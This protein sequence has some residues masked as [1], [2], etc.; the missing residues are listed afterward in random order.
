MAK[1]SCVK[2]LDNDP[3]IIIRTSYVRICQGDITAAALLSIFEYWH[4]SKLAARKNHIDMDE[5]PVT[6]TPPPPLWQYHKN[7]DLEDQ[8]MGIGKRERIDRARKLLQEMGIIE[9]GRNPNKK[10]KFDA[11]TFY[12]FHPEILNDYLDSLAAASAENRTEPL[13]KAETITAENSRAI[14]KDSHTSDSM[15]KETADAGAPGGMPRQDPP[16]T[17]KAPRKAPGAEKD[18]DWQ[19]WVDAWFDFFKARHGEIAPMFN[20]AQSAALKGLRQYL[21]KVAT[22]IEGKT[23]DDAGFAAW[24]YIL[25]NWDRLREW[26]QEQFDLTVVLKKIN[27][28]LNSLRNGNK[29]NRGTNSSGA[30]TSQQRVDAIKN[31]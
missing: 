23:V 25:D 27:D 3:F 1:T 13:R 14:P 31:Y 6:T 20:G 30:G 11:T 2:R 8:L 29:T 10:Y 5:S 22:P 19:R 12:L 17:K 21:C 26:L 15:N 16:K 7:E 18:H 4:N 28:I 24:N 9:I